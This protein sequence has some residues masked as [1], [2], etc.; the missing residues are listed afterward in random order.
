M[1]FRETEMASDFHKFHICVQLEIQKI[2]VL[3]IETK[4]PRKVWEAR[5]QDTTALKGLIKMN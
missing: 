2:N 5:R 4:K 1:T 3:R